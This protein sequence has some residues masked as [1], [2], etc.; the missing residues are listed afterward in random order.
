M[1]ATGISDRAGPEAAADIEQ[2]FRENRPWQKDVICSYS[3]GA[4]TLV[5]LNDFDPEGKALSD[6]FSDCLAAF[7]ALGEI[8]D[9]GS[10]GVVEVDRL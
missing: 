6:E 10:F 9:E 7:V 5:A 2:E 8:S 1:R 3:E 4:L